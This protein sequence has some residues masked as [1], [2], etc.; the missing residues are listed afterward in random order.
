MISLRLAKPLR[1]PQNVSSCINL[2][3]Y[4]DISDK[5]NLLIPLSKLPIIGSVPVHSRSLPSIIFTSFRFIRN[6]TPA[7]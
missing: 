7:I 1:A 3:R 2:Q 5:V 4:S 6:G